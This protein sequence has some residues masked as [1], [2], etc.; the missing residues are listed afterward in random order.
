[1]AGIVASKVRKARAK[2]LEQNRKDSVAIFNYHQAI[3]NNSFTRIILE[4]VILQGQNHWSFYCR[5]EAC[6][7]VRSVN[8]K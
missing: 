7:G 6:A 2:S 5:S 3:I 4:E 1:M 8:F